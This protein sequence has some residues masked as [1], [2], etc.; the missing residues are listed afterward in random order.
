MFSDEEDTLELAGLE[1]LE[2][3]EE[4]EKEDE[5]DTE[6]AEDTED[7]E[8]DESGYTTEMEEDGEQEEE[9]ATFASP[10]RE[11]KNKSR[12]IPPPPPPKGP[13]EGGVSDSANT[14]N[15]CNLEIK[16]GQ[17]R[18]RT[19]KAH[20]W[21]GEARKSMLSTLSAKKVKIFREMKKKNKKYH[22]FMQRLTSGAQDLAAIRR[23]RLMAR[24]EVGGW[25]VKKTARERKIVTLMNKKKY[26]KHMLAEH[27]DWDLARAKQQWKAD[28][29]SSKVFSKV[30]NGE[31]VV[32][33]NEATQMHL[34]KEFSKSKNIKLTKK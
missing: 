26:I 4:E 27:T 16:P 21:C 7:D 13:K 11:P 6:D 8:S 15:E 12:K 9:E 2:E 3:E 17:P 24:N 25:R 30:E 1:D 23:R 5:E 29:R 20:K 32:G 10:P 33:V 28:L 31:Q 19:M 22:G 34:D 14:C 18:Y